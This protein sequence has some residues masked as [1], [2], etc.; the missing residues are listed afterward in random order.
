[1]CY[2]HLAGVVG[3]SVTEALLERGLLREHNGGYQMATD[4]ELRAAA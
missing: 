1:M 3:V 4:G 2:D